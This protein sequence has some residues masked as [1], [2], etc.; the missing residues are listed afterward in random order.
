MDTNTILR[1]L[2]NSGYTG[3]GTDGASIFMEDPNCIIRNFETFAEYAW[4]IIVFITIIL[5]VGWAMAMLRG[6]NNSTLSSIAN[7]MRSLLIMFA[8]L[9]MAGPIINMIWGGDLF[10]R[11]CRQISVP[12]E[13]IQKILDSRDSHFNAASTDLYEGL[14]IYDSGVVI[15]ADA[16]PE[17]ITDD[18]TTPTPQNVTQNASASGDVPQTV[19]ESGKDVIYDYGNGNRQIRRDGTRSW[20][21]NNPGNLRYSEFSRRAGAIASAGGFAVFPDEETGM[22]AIRSLLRTQTYQ[23]LTVA[24]A[25]SRYA[26]PSENNTAKYNKRISELTGMDTNLRVA[27]LSDAQI[28]RMASAIREIEG[29]RVGTITK[30]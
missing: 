27:D 8:V 7:N 21:N 29:W 1:L 6:S 14:E 23:K 26:P 22:A 25:I 3:L 17:N 12:I 20:R 28:A 13:E 11:G 30:E 16:A 4:T 19:T 9:S 18:A 24:Q 2:K 10:K 15:G 5:L